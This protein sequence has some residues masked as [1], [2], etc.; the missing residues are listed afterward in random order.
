VLNWLWLALAEQGRGNA[1]EARRWSEKARA[2][3][4]QYA[5]GMPDR[6][7]E[8]LGLELHNWLEAHIL[9]REVEALLRA[10]PNAPK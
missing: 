5:T 8:E 2:W 1:G 6:A 7:Q 10:S 9:S 3:L 4:D